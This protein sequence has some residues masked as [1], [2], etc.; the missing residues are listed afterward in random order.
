MKKVLLRETVIYVVTLF[1]LAAVLHPDLLS[2]PSVRVGLLSERGNY[3]HPLIY[4]GAF[5]LV[6]GI[7]R[8]IFRYIRRFF[9]GTRLKRD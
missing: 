7:F 3:L 6:I 9:P 8:L 5:Y 1:F 4:A 2:N